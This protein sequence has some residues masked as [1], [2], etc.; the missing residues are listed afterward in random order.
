M[1]ILGLKEILY[2]EYKLQI[3]P[4]GQLYYQGPGFWLVKINKS[5]LKAC[6]VIVSIYNEQIRYRLIAPLKS[7]I[8]VDIIDL[9]VVLNVGCCITQ[10]RPYTSSIIF[11][12]KSIFNNVISLY[13]VNSCP[14]ILPLVV[15]AIYNNSFKR[16]HFKLGE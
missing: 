12:L 13:P 16:S 14:T 9:T 6:Q 4:V 8:H 2:S 1:K 7:R 11:P 5:I 3:Q 15:Y 10:G